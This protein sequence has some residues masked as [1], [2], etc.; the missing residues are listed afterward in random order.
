MI[1]DIFSEKSTEKNSLFFYLYLPFFMIGVSALISSWF[2]IFYALNSKSFLFF[3]K[4][5]TLLI[6]LPPLFKWIGDIKKSYNKSKTLLIFH[7][8]ILIFFL[9]CL[10]PPFDWDEV[11]YNLALPSQYLKLGGFKYISDYGFYSA[12]PLFSDA[13]N[14]MLLKGSN[15]IFP[16]FIGIYSYISLGLITFF[17]CK[18]LKMRGLFCL[19]AATL[20]LSS[21]SIFSLAPTAKPDNLITTY[22]LISFYLAL[23]TVE[24]RNRNLKLFGIFASTVFLIFACGFKYS[25]LYLFPAYFLIFIFTVF[26]ISKDDFFKNL[27]FLTVIGI[28][29]FILINSVWLIRNLIETGNPIYPLLSEFFPQKLQYHFTAY[30]ETLL[31]EFLGSMKDMSY[32]Q[33]HSIFVFLKNI[34]NQTFLIPYLFFPVLAIKYLFSKNSKVNII[35]ILTLATTVTLLELFFLLPWETRHIVTINVLVVVIFCYFLNALIKAQAYK[36][37]SFFFYL[38]LVLMLF[39]KNLQ[40]LKSYPVSCFSFNSKNSLNCGVQKAT[41]GKVAA[42]LNSTLD[43]TDRVA[44]N[45]QPFFYL[46]KS[47]LFIFPWVEKPNLLDS[48]EPTDMLSKLKSEKVTYIAWWKQGYA[49]STWFDPAK[50]PNLIRWFSNTE[51]N[52]YLLEKRGFIKE[53]A[54]VDGITIY[55]LQ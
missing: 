49:Y 22:I 27:I 34:K 48:D 46:N 19:L 15:Y 37:I 50:G 29:S 26:K 2:G 30:R 42:F 24:L 13:L 9:S 25:T 8:I 36:K 45:I 33:S 40:M 16:H 4:F 35:F 5:L 10:A 53:I 20:T 38:C 18:L 21:P 47:Y 11:A 44:L 55:R 51:N 12:F 7:L 32:N 39:S 14:T 23:L 28:F 3:S 52:I 17:I 31:S 6:F 1:L 54:V 41:F 43:E